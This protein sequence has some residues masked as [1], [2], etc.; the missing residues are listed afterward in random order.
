V[1][2]GLLDDR[3]QGLLG[4]APRFQEAGEVRTLAEFRNAQ[5]DRAGAGFPGAVAVAIAMGE[6]IGAAAAMRCAGQALDL[7]VHPALRGEADHLA[8]EVR[9]GG[10]LQQCLQVHGGAGGHCQVRWFGL[11]CGNQILT[12][13]HDDR[14]CG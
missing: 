14:R 10:L 5:L 2:I 12:G 3:G 8:Q 9:V 1:D 11:R 6:P 13:T 4:R 7:E